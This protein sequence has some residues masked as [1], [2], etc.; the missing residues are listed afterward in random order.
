[1]VETKEKKCLSKSNAGVKRF[2][3]ETKETI[4]QNAPE[5]VLI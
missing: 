5:T 4:N 1:L 3:V 2:V